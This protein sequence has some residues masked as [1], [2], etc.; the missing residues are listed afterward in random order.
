MLNSFRSSLVPSE[1]HRAL[2]TWIP[3]AVSDCAIRF[4][5][6]RLLAFWLA[7]GLACQCVTA[8]ELPF[9]DAT[10]SGSIVEWLSPVGGVTNRPGILS[11]ATRL[12]SELRTAVS[13]GQ[14]DDDYLD[15]NYVSPTYGPLNRSMAD[16]LGY[17][18]KVEPLFGNDDAQGETWA[19]HLMPEGLMYKSYLAGEKEPRMSTAFLY[20]SKGEVNWDS[21]LGGRVGLLR[22]G[23]GRG[24]QP[25]G[26]QFDVEGGAF[27]RM[28]P[29]EERDVKAVDFRIGAPITYREGP[30]QYKFGYYHISSHLGD[31]FLLKNPGFPRRNYS[32]DSLVLGM[33]YFP[34]DELR[35]YFEV[36]WAFYTTGGALP[37]EIQT[38][39]EWSSNRP[40]GW[41]GAP[42]AAVNV[43]LRE[44]TDW[45]GSIN[46]IAGWQWRGST[47]D[48]L[49]RTGIQFFNGAN[50]QYSFLG[51]NQ[52]VVG[53]GIRYDY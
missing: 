42:Y 28:Q 45:G 25:E 14:S 18:D 15:L 26:W 34:I 38:G 21:V 53:Y 23:T 40:T 13:R 11:V 2:P 52:Q 24:I 5:T 39:I 41:R 30:F 51:D 12:K 4:W 46:I 37:W 31:E 50:N 32:R 43:H 17:D 10:D 16:P 9:M 48:H 29:Q 49:F 22:Y 35:L 7:L 1:T 36:G 44:E 27:L 19:W 3:R 6:S 20:P 33:G 8:A 47:S